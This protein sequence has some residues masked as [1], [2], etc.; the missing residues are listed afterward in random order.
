[1][2]FR[3]LWISLAALVAL[4]AI[5]LVGGSVWSTEL[6]AQRKFPRSD[7]REDRRDFFARM[8][9]TL[10]SSGSARRIHS[11]SLTA[12]GQPGSPLADLHA[13]QIR[14]DVNWRAIFGGAWRVEQ[15]DVLHLDGT[16]RPATPRET[17]QG[18]EPAPKASRIG[19]P[20][21]ET[22][23]ARP[24]HGVAGES[25]D[26]RRRGFDPRPR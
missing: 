6:P 1:M 21:A 15:V 3:A 17:H 16:L 2:R 7:R 5:A 19:G 10:R 26:G 4:A 12:T 14:A 18:D 25:R 13:E 23:R 22:F 8:P 20:A 24:P 11:D 9:N